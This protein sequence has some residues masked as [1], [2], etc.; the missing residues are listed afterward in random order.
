MKIITASLLALTLG[1]GAVSA[2]TAPVDLANASKLIRASDLEDGNIYSVQA[3]IEQSTFGGTT[4]TTI[5][6]AWDDVGEI[7][8]I[9]LDE[10]GQVFGVIAEIGG[11]LDV[12]SRNVL[13]PISEVAVV[14]EENGKYSFLTRFSQ[15]ELKSMPAIN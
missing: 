1:A 5:D 14:P 13:L 11:F 6:T 15:E 7:E 8:D 4:Y 3:G 10:K 9:V 12:G 2:Q